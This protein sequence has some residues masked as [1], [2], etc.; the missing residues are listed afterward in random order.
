MIFQT[1]GFLHVKADGDHMCSNI[2]GKAVLVEL[3]HTSHLSISGPLRAQLEN[4]C[5]LLMD[6]WGH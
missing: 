4:H 5:R 1:F 2:K 6:L 3:V